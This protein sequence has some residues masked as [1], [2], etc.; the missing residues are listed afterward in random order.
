MKVIELIIK[1]FRS[2]ITYEVN[3]EQSKNGVYFVTVNGIPLTSTVTLDRREAD[4]FFEKA[5]EYMR[6]G[7]E[8]R[9][10]AII[11]SEKV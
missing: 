6:T 8:T 9:E 1:F 11:K 2:F 7:E 10:D 3:L 4:L 5:K